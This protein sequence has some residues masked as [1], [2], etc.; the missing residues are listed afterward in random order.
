MTPL[1]TEGLPS[2]PKIA[3]QGEVA[4][5][6]RVTVKGE[7]EVYGD[8]TVVGIEAT[9]IKVAWDRD[10]RVCWSFP[11][12][13]EL[14]ATPKPADPTSEV[15]ERIIEQCALVAERYT[16]WAGPHE[17]SD[18]ETKSDIAQAIRAL[19]TNA[20]EQAKGVSDDR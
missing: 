2:S 13:I 12:D 11:D 9:C 14:L 17:M 10:P 8:G 6:A 20:H 4:I 19:A 15:V 7:R 16:R 5:G 18:E 3:E 1:H